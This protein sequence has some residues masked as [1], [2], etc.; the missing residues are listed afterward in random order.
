MT[1]SNTYY[2]TGASVSL[3]AGTW[4]ITSETTVQQSSDDEDV[5]VVLGTAANA[6]YTQGEMNSG[7][8]GNRVVT[9]SLSKIVVLSSTT[10]VA[11]YAAGTHSSG[12]ILATPVDNA[13]G[14]THVATAIHAFQIK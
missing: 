14:N 7:H 1:S 9:I 4:L 6:A 11:T 10:T 13:N 12:T 8:D 2:A 5:T 3:G